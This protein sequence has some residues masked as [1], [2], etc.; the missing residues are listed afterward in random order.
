MKKLILST[1]FALAATGL[2]FGQGTVQWTTLSPAQFTVE[3]NTTVLSYLSTPGASL[4]ASQTIGATTAVAGSFYYELLYTAAGTAA[5]TTLS[6]LD[7][8]SD[9]GLEGENNGSSAGRAVVL[10]SSSDATVPFT[11]ASEIMMVGWSANLGTS[12]SAV[13]TVLNSLT[14]E[15]SVVG[16]MLFGQSGVA[17][18]TP[19]AAG[20]SPGAVPI[21][22]SAS[23]I[24]SLLTPLEVVST[25]PEPTTIALGAMGALSLLALRRKK[26]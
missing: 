4:P 11:A 20:T 21:G 15:Q 3:T 7:N 2:A 16:T 17:L 26:A 5:P 19:D 13:S 22:P 8:W 10:G 12:W 24:D 18:F 6:A 14:A 23:Q 1:T 25:V 9:S